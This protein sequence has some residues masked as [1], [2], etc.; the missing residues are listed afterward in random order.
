MHA[1]GS[2]H[3]KQLEARTTTIGRNRSRFDTQPGMPIAS[4]RTSLFVFGSIFQLLG[5]ACAARVCATGVGSNRN[6]RSHGARRLSSIA[7]F[8]AARH[9]RADTCMMFVAGRGRG[10]GPPA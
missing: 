1:V 9:A 7:S 6:R 5:L 2:T 3:Y 4:R 10:G 8:A